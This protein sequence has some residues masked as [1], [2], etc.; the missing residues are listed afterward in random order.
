MVGL[1]HTLIGYPT[2]E[3]LGILDHIVNEKI[4]MEMNRL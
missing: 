2:A 1:G 3:D 4:I